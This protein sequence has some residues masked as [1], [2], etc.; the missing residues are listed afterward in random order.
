MAP[1][2]FDALKDYFGDFEVVSVEEKLFE[3]IKDFVENEYDF[4][5]FIDLVIKTKD[6]KYHVIDWK[7]CS[8]GWDSRKK[9]DKMI[10]YQLT[11][12]KYYFALK[13]NIDPENIETYFGL[14]IKLS[15]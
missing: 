6:E 2:S 12:Y 10:S 3:P 14:A 15:I 8:W 13:H 11:F 4:K 1:L 9:S 5:G 7:T